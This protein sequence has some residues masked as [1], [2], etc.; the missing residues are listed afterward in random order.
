MPNTIFVLGTDAQKCKEL[1]E[2]LQDRIADAI[3]TSSGDNLPAVHESDTVIIT[4]E[5]KSTGVL[6]RRL[7][8]RLEDQVHRAQFLGEL[9]RLLPSS[10][11]PEE[12]V[13]KIA[14]K[15]TEI[16]GETAFVVLINDANQ[17]RLDAAHSRNPE[18]LIKM[19]TT[20]L[21]LAPQGLPTEEF[22]EVLE[23]RKPRFIENLQILDLPPDLRFLVD[24]YALSSLIAV[25]IQTKEYVLGAFVTVASA[26]RVFNQEDLEL[27]I[28]LSDFA[29]IGIENA[30]LFVELQKSAI[31]DSLTGL[32]NTRFF[33]EV[34]SRE[35]ARA[36][37]YS[38]PLSLLM[39]DV[40][41]F[42][43]VNDTFGHLVG[44]KVLTQIGRALQKAVR[45]TDFVFRCGGDEFGVV[46][47]GTTL[48]G[49]I[50]A[51]EKV[52]QK[53]EQSKILEALGHTGSVTV[54]IGISEFRRGNHHE[55]M[56]AEADQA[57]YVSKRASKNCARAFGT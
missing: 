46:L 49:A 2:I 45:N 39:I 38:S 15:S 9:I 19:L 3:V 12:L 43:M 35:A 42:K 17:L 54:S 4:S 29:A 41:G 34:L 18:A 14:A 26:P 16:L 7:L 11:R 23:G 51:A 47:P 5:E 28:E 20:T 40:D 32:Y 10:H 53:V 31:T 24:K 6:Y 21:N 44:N 56:V 52:L 1:R 27:A 36:D 57:L 50:R 55:S 33:N 37:R 48:E 8:N 30:S 22:R 25:P 13:E